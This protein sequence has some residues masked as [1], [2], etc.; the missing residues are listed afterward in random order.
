MTL[1]W[2]SSND[3]GSSGSCLRKV[4]IE[5]EEL[6]DAEILQEAY[7]LAGNVAQSY[8][9]DDTISRLMSEEARALYPASFANQAV[10]DDKIMRQSQNE[11]HD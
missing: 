7:H 3:S 8:A 1:S 10:L 4:G 5:R 9:A 6:C 2:V 11:Q